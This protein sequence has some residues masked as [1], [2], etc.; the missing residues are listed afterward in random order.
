[1]VAISSTVA[2]TGSYN[3]LADKPTIPAAVTVDSSITS[4]G[5]NPVQGGAIYSALTDKANIN[6]SVDEVF[7]ASTL[8]VC[9]NDEGV[10]M[11]AVYSD[12]EMRLLFTESVDGG[13]LNYTFDGSGSAKTIAT[14]ADI[15]SC[16]PTTRKIN[17]KPLSTDVTLTASDVNAQAVLVSGTNI[18]TINSQSLL[19]EGNLTIASGSDGVG[20]ASVVQTTTSNT[21]GGNNIITVT[22]TDGSSSTFTVKN[23]VDG[24]NGVSLG[25]IALMQE[26][27]DSTSSVMS[28]AAVTESIE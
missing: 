19:G 7:N 2:Y 13:S 12:D 20:I 28:Q 15:A 10:M 4:G 26:T 14:T 23:G 21:S 3:D 18:K 24:A 11:N 17:N 8:Q 25:E 16:V 27:G 22:K 6:G 5:T 1:M 9:S